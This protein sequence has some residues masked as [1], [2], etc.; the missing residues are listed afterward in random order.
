M[1][2][3]LTWAPGSP[4]GNT[5]T[6]AGGCTCK[7]PAATFHARWPRA[8]REQVQSSD[9]HCRIPNAEDEARK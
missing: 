7:Q 3:G 8:L 6:K 2:A 4:A 1:S 5:C 9:L